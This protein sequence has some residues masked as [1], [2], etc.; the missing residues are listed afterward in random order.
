MCPVATDE[1][2]LGSLDASL[3]KNTAYI[4]RL[5]LLTA[6]TGDSLLGEFE[7]LKLTKY[8]GEAAHALV[9]SRLKNIGDIVMVVELASRFHQRYSD[10]LAA[11]KAALGKE[12]DVLEPVSMDDRLAWLS[13]QR[14]LLR[15]VA[16]LH[17]VGIITEPN[18][19]YKLLGKL[20]VDDDHKGPPSVPVATGFVKGV[21][22]FYLNLDLLDT[23]KE[24]FLISEW[25]QKFTDALNAFFKAMCR[26]L[27]RTH[28]R[29]RILEAKGRH[30]YETRGDLSSSQVSVLQATAEACEKLRTNLQS[31]AEQLHLPLPVMEELEVPK[32][33]EGRIVFADPRMAA[34][35]ERIASVIFDSEEDRAFYEGIV[36][37]HGLVPE[38]FL[39][40]SNTSRPSSPAI[41]V[42]D[43]AEVDL[44]MFVD[45]DP[46]SVVGKPIDE[47][48]S[49]EDYRSVNSIK[50]FFE[51]LPVMQS[52]A[53]ADQAAI[54]YCY[55][56]S[57]AMQ[58]RLAE[59]LI[60][61]P[62]R[63][64]D[65]LPFIGRFLATLKP[66]Y[67]ELGQAI[68]QSL[69]GQFV[70]LIHR[71]EPIMGSRSRICRFIGELTKFRVMPQGT[72]YAML[73]KAILDHLTGF[74]IDMTSILLES[75][76]RFLFHQP[77]SHRRLIHLFETINKKKSQG[78][79]IS[80]IVL[81]E[82][83]MYMSNPPVSVSMGKPPKPPRLQYILKLIRCDLEP[84]N[85]DIVFKQIRKCPWM[86]PE[87]RQEL[88]K[89]FGKV[90]RVKYSNICLLASMMGTFKRLYPDFVVD[91]V[92][93]VCEEIR[94][95]LESNVLRNN[96]RILALVKYLG[97]LFCYSVVE[98]DLMF[99][100]LHQLVTFGHPGVPRIAAPSS[101][102][103][104]SSHFRIRLIC[105]VLQSCSS[106]LLEGA[107]E[108]RRR[109]EVFL[110]LF[111]YYIG[112]KTQVPNDI[113]YLLD[114]TFEEL[115]RKRPSTEWEEAL[116]NLNN[117]VNGQFAFLLDDRNA[118]PDL[119]VQGDEAP[120]VEMAPNA[121]L[122]IRRTDDFDKALSGL[123][124]ESVD[125]RK[126][127]RRVGAF[128]APLPLAL[129]TSSR[130][131]NSS[132]SLRMLV[133]KKNKTTTRELPVDPA[134]VH[135]MEST[136]RGR[137]RGAEEARIVQQLVLESQATSRGVDVRKLGGRVASY[138]YGGK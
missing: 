41:P 54:D 25:R 21:G 128:D 103:P 135:F 40:G 39:M 111:A 105:I 17:L 20:L 67:P 14:Q 127:Q 47:A 109:Y 64:L 27:V 8:V 30:H 125:E 126:L 34:S 19:V 138:Q 98:S 79:D 50:T 69:V 106:L 118:D 42:D 52:R 122:S 90:W 121:L 81:L 61:L 112:T 114:D 88:T 86:D 97:E 33:M 113:D 137:E 101:I 74:N 10:F 133:R 29:L 123:M 66:F 51:K 73:K 93:G 46:D 100:L 107:S 132:S 65:L 2:Q 32:M 55:I 120:D 116:G 91:L 130:D 12:V 63:R 102:D 15:L 68:V 104:P 78:M 48:L 75:C 1:N 23:Q 76:G 85:A 6:E 96:Q 49:A 7:L 3:K 45:V 38:S 92:D 117:L 95:C 131:A 9:E 43:A 84:S 58:K 5:R 26:L 119:E 22:A 83:A 99:A 71:K 80:Q 77:E 110:A 82:N 53:L 62:F 16:E 94:S 35:V 108:N 36:D 31:L 60:D 87:C 115:D 59:T 134:K 28:N 18:A 70:F 11:F 129:L 44:G 89:A 37:L 57:K 124:A 24:L 4:K 136:L 72:V 56:H 13:R